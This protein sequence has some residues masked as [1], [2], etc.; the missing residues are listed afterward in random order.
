LE[1]SRPILAAE[2]DQV[3]W[4]FFENETGEFK[5]RV[6]FG[7]CL[8]LLDEALDT[9]W[10][11]DEFELPP[12]EVGNARG[13]AGWLA[14]LAGT[15]PAVFAEGRFFS[16]LAVGLFAAM[17]LGFVAIIS[18]VWTMQA[19]GF[20]RFSAMAKIRVIAVIRATLV[21]SSPSALLGKAR[22]LFR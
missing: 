7:G 6:G 4:G 12:L 11:G 14:L 21:L 2:L 17:A 19:L 16:T 5:K 1:K 8:E 10:L 15:T 3:A 18:A 22:E 20:G 9:A 13:L